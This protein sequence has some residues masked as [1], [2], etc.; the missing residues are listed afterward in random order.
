MSE[1]ADRR[2][3]IVERAAALARDVGPK[4][5]SVLLTHFP[6]A[7]TL[8]TLRPGAEDLG[9]VAAVNRAVA[10]ELAS[11]GVQVVVQVADR[12]AFRRWLDGRADTP[13]NRLAWRHRGH[14][15]H[16]DAALGVLGLDPKFARPRPASGKSPGKS[17][18]NSSGPSAGTPADRL[19]RAFAK[20]GGAEFE[21]LA[22]ELLNAGR[23]GVLDLAIRKAGE[24][25]G[26]DAADDLAMELLALAEGAAIGP[27][28]WAEL[29]ALPVALPPDGAPKP[30]ALGESLVAAGVLPDSIELQFLPG[31]RSPAALAQLNP[32]AL[33]RVLLD[34]VAGKPPAA[35]PPV[36]VESLAEDGFGVLLG[37]QLDWSIPVWEEIVANGLPKLPEEGEETPEAAA[38]ATAF[39][40]WRTAVHEA[41]EGCVPLAL[42][43]ASEVEAEIADFLDEA[44]EE[45]GG[46]E[47]IREFVAVARGEAPGEEVVCR[48]EIIGDG[49]ELSL[50]TTGGRFLDSLSLSAGQMPARAEEMLRLVSSFVPLVKDT[51][52]H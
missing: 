15:L 37:L 24:R 33:R 8:D 14:L 4:L 20:E 17:S 42:V 16:G 21:A 31:W 13:E 43:P 7:D 46:L 29:V 25:F 22:Q 48:P 30:E 28:G 19:L 34:M 23:E 47:E 44:G 49:L 50:Y 3:R 40:R 1:A 39:D 2:A 27:S 18:G 35:V 6:D 45:I 36:A 11:A 38:R 26:E 32:F 9:T 12:A 10:A 51:P 52:G 41:N 5:A